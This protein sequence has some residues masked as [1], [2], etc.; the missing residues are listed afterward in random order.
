MS[1]AATTTKLAVDDLIHNTAHE[2]EN[3]TAAEAYEAAANLE[4]GVE[5][6]NFRLGGIFNRIN[7]EG[8]YAD[9]GFGKFSE[10][11]ED[12][13][14]VK[15]S[16]AMHLIKIYR[17]LT[18]SGVTWEAVGH[19]GWSK[20]AVLSSI[21]TKKNHKSWVKKAEKASVI[22]LS[23]MVREAKAESGG[24]TDDAEPGDTPSVSSMTFKVHDDQKEA[25]NEAIDKAKV[26]SGS[27]HSNQALEAICLD[28][29]A[30]PS[31]PKLEGKAEDAPTGEYTLE[32]LKIYME[33]FGH[34]EVLGVFEKIWPDVNLTLHED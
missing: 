2:I 6:S 23:E 3:Y 31:K 7:E 34:M 26:E 32:G 12:R 14:G 1:E 33:Q 24:S 28:Y 18:E 27:E 4:E 13:F 16:K 20:L 11:V 22:Q 19:V 15:R 8:W 25:I 17:D 9:E 29:L 30:G 10:F 5:F 21:L